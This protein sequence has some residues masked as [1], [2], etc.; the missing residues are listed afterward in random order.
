[1]LTSFKPIKALSPPPS[2]TATDNAARKALPGGWS[3][4]KDLSDPHVLEIAKYA[5]KEQNK[6]NPTR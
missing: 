4:I 6:K 1:M 5:V 2:A 3:S